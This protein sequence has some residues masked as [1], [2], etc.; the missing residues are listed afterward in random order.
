MF[1]TKSCSKI[2][3]FSFGKIKF[4]FVYFEI[5]LKISEKFN[6]SNEN[7]PTNTNQSIYSCL[8]I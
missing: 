1:P 2:N 3:K 4:F 5:I 8:F 6:C 7:L